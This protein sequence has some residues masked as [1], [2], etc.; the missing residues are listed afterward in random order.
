MKNVSRIAWALCAIITVASLVSLVTTLASQEASHNIFALTGTVIGNLIPVVFAVLA[1]LILSRQPHN[2]IG[3]LLLLPALLG[4]LPVEPYIRSFT[5]APAHPPVLLLLAL[6][7]YAWSWLPLI[8]P[9]F[10]IPVL[11]PTGRP[12]S[13]RWRWLIIAGLVMCA[14][15]LFLVTFT[16]TYATTDL[17]MNWS[18]T[19]PIGFLPSDVFGVY[20]FVPWVAGLFSLTLLSVASLF[21]RYRR[22]PALEREQIKWLLYACALFAA[23]Y[24][25]LYWISD[26]TTMIRDVWN[27]L[28]YISILAIPVAITVAILRY[29]L[30]DIDVIIRRTLIYGALTLTLALAYFG[31]VVLLQELFRV[32]TGQHQSPIATVI[33]TLGIAALFTP[34]RRRI[35]N[36]IDRRFYRK[37]Y[38]AEKTVAA[39]GASLRQEVDLEQLSDR[40][41]TVVDDAMQPEVVSLWLRPG[42][43][44]KRVLDL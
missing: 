30:W 13:P 2:V 20:F 37:K 22:A 15:F 31:S 29:R 38:D 5:S 28:F 43:E 33:S 34:L 32:I 24:I 10:F 19:N 11:F 16:Q 36:D 14:I 44:K 25:P 3:W 12:P 40:L 39:F 41:V 26:L 18:V 6:W 17:G 9:I 21:I 35:Q 4:I 8:F 42:M 7:F 27:M 23:I 1:A